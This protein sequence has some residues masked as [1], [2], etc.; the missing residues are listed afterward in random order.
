MSDIAISIEGITPEL[1]EAYRLSGMDRGKS[2]VRALDWTFGGSSDVFAIARQGG[3]IVGLSS[4]IPTKIK[5]GH[6]SGTA[7]QA[8]DSFVSPDLRGKGLFTKLAG[9]YEEHTSKKGHDLIWGFPNDNAAPA[10]FKKI[11]W[12]KHGQ[13]PFLIKPLRAGYFFRKLRLPFDFHLSTSRDQRI[14]AVHKLGD[15]ADAL[16]EN[17]SHQ[18]SVGT[19]RDRSYLM[20]R[21]FGSPQSDRYRIVIDASTERGALVATREEYKHGGHIAYLMEAMGGASLDEL[22]QSEIG[23]LRERG[24]EVVLG[25]SFPWSPNYRSLRRAGFLPLPER[26]RPIRVWFGSRALSARAAVSANAGKWYLSYLDSD[27]V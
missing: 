7:F 17:F 18:V 3:R 19:I 14:A 22:L 2:G 4:Y 5:L 24:A 1:I 10:W 11:G 6:V 9:T 16:W 15:W 20:H 25:W 26:L 12:T 13:V 27:T 21:L 23:R 8:V